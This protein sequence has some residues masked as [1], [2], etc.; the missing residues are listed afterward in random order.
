MSRSGR[1]TEYVDINIINL[2]QRLQSILPRLRSWSEILAFVFMCGEEDAAAAVMTPVVRSRMER[3]SFQIV[4]PANGRRVGH[5]PP[6]Q[7][8]VP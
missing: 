7:A 1:S 8:D 3:C 2:H 4:D 6:K 5:A